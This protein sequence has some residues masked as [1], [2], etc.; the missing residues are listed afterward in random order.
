MKICYFGTYKPGYSRSRVLVEGFRE[1]GVEVVMCNTSLSGISKYFDL[2][3]KHSKIKNEYDVM[4]VG[5]PGY[6]T[7]VLARFL[8]RKKIVF[9]A[10]SSIF[11]SMVYDRKLVKPK[12]LKAL[13]YWVLDWLSCKLV[14][15]VLLDTQ[16]NIDYFVE[17]FGINEEKFIRVFVGSV[18][19]SK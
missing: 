12:T 18:L 11:D 16:A 6:H 8:T 19:S 9:D 2:I 15:V 13:Y 1:N 3:R 4:L 7:A 14:H 10:F 5:F 17:T